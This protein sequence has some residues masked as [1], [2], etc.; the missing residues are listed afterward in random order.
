MRKN[1]RERRKFTPE[2]KAEVVG[3]CAVGDRSIG[4]VAKDLD[5][6]QTAVR[7]SVRL[8][9]IWPDVLCCAA[10]SAAGGSLPCPGSRAECHLA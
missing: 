3:P 2:S 10:T 8:V 1:R 4:R 9:E 5:L 6:T 7:D